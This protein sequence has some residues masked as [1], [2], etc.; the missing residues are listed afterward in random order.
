MDC[1]GVPYTS[2]TD[3]AIEICKPYP[4]LNPVANSIF[5]CKMHC[6]P[7]GPSKPISG[8]PSLPKN[9]FN[10]S[11]N[12][13][14]DTLGVKLILLYKLCGWSRLS[15][16]VINSDSCHPGWCFFTEDF[17]YCAAKSADYRVFFYCYNFA[18]LGG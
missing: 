9:L 10:E 5:F 8:S 2:E 11:L 16:S 17:C 15:E 6:M 14:V 12:L 7:L 18:C 1:N 4:R 13:F 3:T